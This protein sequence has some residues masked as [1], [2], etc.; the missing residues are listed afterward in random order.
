MLLPL[1]FPTKR[2]FSFFLHFLLWRSFI[3]VHMNCDN[4][5]SSDKHHLM[6][7]YWKRPGIK[8]FNLLSFIYG[9]C[10]A[11]SVF[12]S[13]FSLKGNFPKSTVNCLSDKF[14]LRS[15]SPECL[16][17]FFPFL[18]MSLWIGR[19]TEKWCIASLLP[20]YMHNCNDF[21]NLW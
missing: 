7:N 10:T 13:R 14:Q 17:R 9:I 5:T 18:I 6:S 3:I 1:W 2:F 15:T 21:G 11:V 12:C 16:E 4:F 19:E 8:I 20:H